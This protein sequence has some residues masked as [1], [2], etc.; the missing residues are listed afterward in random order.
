MANLRFMFIAT[1]GNATYNG[2]EITAP[3]E[4]L[5]I[6]WLWAKYAPKDEV[7]GSPTF[8]EPL[9]RTPA[10]EVQAYRNYAAA[11]WSGTRANVVRWKL[12][13]DRAAVS[14]PVLPE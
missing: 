4:A 5:F 11:M 13:Q 9:T 7:E 10:N 2:P 14:A 12:E 3:Q 8:G 1:A 6:D